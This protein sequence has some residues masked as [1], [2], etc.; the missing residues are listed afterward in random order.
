VP[1]T[2]YTLY[3]WASTSYSIS[4]GEV[5]HDNT[6]LLV[7]KSRSG[8][9]ALPLPKAGVMVMLGNGSTPHKDSVMRF[10]W[11][12]NIICFGNARGKWSDVLPAQACEFTSE[13][14]ATPRTN[15]TLSVAP[16]RHCLTCAYRCLTACRVIAIGL[17]ASSMYPKVT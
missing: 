15:S 13:G 5:A 8:P 1:P 2:G 3:L 6:T 7:A 16:G 9:Q 14:E 4:Q 12:Q 11:E 10:T 17:F